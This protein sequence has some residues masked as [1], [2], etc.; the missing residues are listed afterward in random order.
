[1]YNDIYN[2]S[3]L[4][5]QKNESVQHFSFSKQS[6][7]N[8]K[9]HFLQSYIVNTDT[10]SYSLTE[11]GIFLFLAD[12]MQVVDEEGGRS[13]GESNSRDCLLAEKTHREKSPVTNRKQ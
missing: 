9:L 2:K 11:R 10:P 3:Q 8:K 5:E 1:M 13:V 6:E 12:M 4:C 7:L